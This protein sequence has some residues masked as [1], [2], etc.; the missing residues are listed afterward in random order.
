MATFSLTAPNRRDFS[1]KLLAV[2]E[3]KQIKKQLQQQKTVNSDALEHI[4]S[5]S[6]GF[7]DACAKCVSEP[8]LRNARGGFSA[9]SEAR[10]NARWKKGSDALG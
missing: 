9:P 4:N 6:R 3:N 2:R 7:F 8:L 5:R 1:L 10:R